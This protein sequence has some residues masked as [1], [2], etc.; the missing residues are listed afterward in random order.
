MISPGDT[1][2]QCTLPSCVLTCGLVQQDSGSDDPAVLGEELLHLLLAH[3]L[4]EAT[5]VQVG[6]PDRGRTG[7]CIGHLG[8]IRGQ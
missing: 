4:G 1:L 6:I 5:D 7:T 3:G 8:G 2:V